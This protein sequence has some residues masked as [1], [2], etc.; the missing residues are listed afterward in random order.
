M[1][2][3]LV[4]RALAAGSVVSAATA[5]RIGAGCLT[6]VARR[7]PPLVRLAVRGSAG[8]DA[9]EAQWAFRDELIA[10]ARDCAEVSWHHMRRAVD[11]LDAITRPVDGAPPAAPEVYRPYR[12]KA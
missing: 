2:R 11:E 4:P 7:T 12:V 9:G 5:V 10:L 3:L 1:S 6:L 8:R